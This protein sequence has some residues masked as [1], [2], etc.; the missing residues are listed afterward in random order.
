MQNAPVHSSEG[1]AAADSV[2]AFCLKY[3][4]NSPVTAADMTTF[5]AVGT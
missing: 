4:F 1:D 5:V 3:C 2:V